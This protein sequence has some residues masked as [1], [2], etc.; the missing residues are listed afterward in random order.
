MMANSMTAQAMA[1]GGTGATVLLVLVIA[2]MARA[3][4]E[5]RGPSEVRL[6]R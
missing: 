1:Q 2:W 6:G 4:A 5:L 3:D